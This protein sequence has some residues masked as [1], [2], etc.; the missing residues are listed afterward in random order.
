[1]ICSG[2]KRE[3]DEK[4]TAVKEQKSEKA[5]NTDMTKSALVLIEYLL[6]LKI[7]VKLNLKIRFRHIVNLTATLSF[8]DQQI[9]MTKPL[10]S[11]KSMYF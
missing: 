8:S 10:Y 5:K 1:M 2:K 9:Q 4:D 7:W 3:N 11:Q 6:S